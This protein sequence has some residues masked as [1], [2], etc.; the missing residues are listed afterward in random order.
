M[1]IGTILGSVQGATVTDKCEEEVLRGM[2]PGE[3]LE[4]VKREITRV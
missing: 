4:D 3:T 2:I 1:I